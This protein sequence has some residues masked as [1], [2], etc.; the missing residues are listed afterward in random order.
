MKIILLVLSL[1]V[2][3]PF[4]FAKPATI[5]RGIVR[6]NSGVPVKHA[7]V[8]FVSAV[9]QTNIFT[10]L[11]DEHGK[12]VLQIAESPKSDDSNQNYFMNQN[13]P[14]PFSNQTVIEYYIKESVSV[15]VSVFDI[16]GRKVKT[17]NDVHSSTK[18]QWLT[19]NGT[20]DNGRYISDGVYFIAIEGEQGIQ[21]KK[22]ILLNNFSSNLTSIISNSQASLLKNSNTV[23]DFQEC[24]NVL[25]ENSDLTEPKILPKSIKNIVIYNE[26]IMDFQ[27]HGVIKE[28]LGLA[29]KLITR[30]VYKNPY[31][32]VS[33]N[34][35]GLWRYN[36]EKKD[37]W[38]CLGLSDTTLL[39]IAREN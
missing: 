16:L 12:Y 26:Q 20:D 5:I 15:K 14:N 19:W 11:T 7:I 25:I 13:Y 34:K 9:D 29:G 38:E 4:N 33:A 21:L 3:F 10:V 1:L 24:Y 30:V 23:R 2:L 22:A 18:I 37:A 17:F 28:F 35:D 32:Y 8:N 36:L 6:T 27:V 31:L 39:K